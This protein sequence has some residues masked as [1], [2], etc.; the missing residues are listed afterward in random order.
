MS[1]ILALLEAL[2]KGKELANKEVWKNAGAL[3][4]IFAVILKA[5]ELSVPELQ[6]NG[7]DHNQIINGFVSLALVLGAYTNV[8]T[9]KTVGIK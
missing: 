4:S 2:Q 7:V 9:S 5:I 3:T 8:A 1:K 6:I